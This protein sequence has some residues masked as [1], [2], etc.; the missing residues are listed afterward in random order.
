[1]SSWRHSAFLFKASF[2]ATNPSCV[3]VSIAPSHLGSANTSGNLESSASDDSEKHHASIFQL[4]PAHIR[5]LRSV[6][7][8]IKHFEE[9]QFIL[10]KLT[11]MNRC[12]VIKVPISGCCHDDK[13]TSTILRVYLPSHQFCPHQP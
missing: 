11:Y 5:S 12:E 6:R 4:R 7:F 13:R 2:L 3:A 9:R 8:G 1:M 10:S